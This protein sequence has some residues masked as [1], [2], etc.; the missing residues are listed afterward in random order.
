MRSQ[1]HR[2]RVRGG[3]Q[4]F[5][6]IEILIVILIMAIL[7]VIVVFAVQNLG[8]SSAR[9]SCKDDLK[10]IEVAAETY[11]AQVG[12]YPNVGDNAAA[13]PGGTP[14]PGGITAAMSA[15]GI[16]ALNTSQPNQTGGTAGPWLK[17]TPTNGNHY[18]IALSA[19]GLDT[20][21]VNDAAGINQPDCSGVQ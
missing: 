2:E 18:S 16:Y 20:I 17:D 1:V 5:T 8:G 11:K 21:T 7:A 4:G 15:D 14:I 6:L 9:T 12:H 13:T 10:N 3:E 19:D